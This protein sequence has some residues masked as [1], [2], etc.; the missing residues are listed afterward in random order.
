MAVFRSRI[1]N[2]LGV[3]HDSPGGL[4][5]LPCLMR[6]DPL[7]TCRD[8]YKRHNGRCRALLSPN[9]TSQLEPWEPTPQADVDIA[10]SLVTDQSSMDPV[11]I[12]E[13]FS[14]ATGLP[15][16]SSPSSVYATLRLTERSVMYIDGNLTELTA[17]MKKDTSRPTLSIS[18]PPFLCYIGPRLPCL[19]RLSCW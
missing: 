6:T 12:T 1:S 3:R 8:V 7:T 17:T 10:P 19:R 5:T 11:M 2:V 9:Q 14:Y 13:A 4:V 15:K 16:Y 18:T